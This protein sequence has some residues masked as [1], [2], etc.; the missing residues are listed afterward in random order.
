[1]GFRCCSCS[2]SPELV[3][4]LTLRLN[5][6]LAPTN[7][8]GLFIF[9]GKVVNVKM[10]QGPVDAGAVRPLRVSCANKT[11]FEYELKGVKRTPFIDAK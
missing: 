5:S 2:D 1:M 9:H 7:K 3:T 4:C 11:C 6:L 10:Q 8:T